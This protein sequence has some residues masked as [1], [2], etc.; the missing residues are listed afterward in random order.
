LGQV[1]Y[2]AKQIITIATLTGASLR[3]HG[4]MTSSIFCNRGETK[5]KI[6]SSFV[7]NQEQAEFFPYRVRYNKLLVNEYGVGDLSN[8]SLLGQEAGH[9]TAAEFVRKFIK[10]DVDLTHID[11]AGPIVDKKNNA[12]GYA[13]RSLVDFIEG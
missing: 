8:I 10:D 7:A 11:L 9:H 1:K 3:S 13:V 6:E 12:T 5:A 4:S 2:Q